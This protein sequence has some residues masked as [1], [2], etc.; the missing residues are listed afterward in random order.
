MSTTSGVSEMKLHFIKLS[1]PTVTNDIMQCWTEGRRSTAVAED[2]RTTA[3]VAEVWG[4][5]YSR[6]SYL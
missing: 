5:S 6:M 2:L 4:H 3:M 1:I